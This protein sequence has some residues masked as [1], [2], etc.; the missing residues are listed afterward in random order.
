MGFPERLRNATGFQWDAGNLEKSSRAHGVE[1]WESE[2]IF[3][4]QPFVV[5]RDEKHS[6][7]EERYFGLGKTDLGRHLLAV[8][9]LRGTE[10]RVISARDMSRRERTVFEKHEKEGQEGS[11]V[12]E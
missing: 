6:T 8:F 11:E 4:N 12:P 10:I 2:E 3:F 7:N 9:T 5:L 1:F